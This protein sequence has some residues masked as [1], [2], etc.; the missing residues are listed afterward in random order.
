ML[1]QFMSREV[2]VSLTH[3]NYARGVHVVR[4]VLGRLLDVSKQN[5]QQINN[6][7]QR[8]AEDGNFRYIKLIH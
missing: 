5:E 4:G 6:G 2:E 8:K 3:Y 1:A 7:V